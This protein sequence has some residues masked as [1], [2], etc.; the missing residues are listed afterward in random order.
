MRRRKDERVMKYIGGQKIWLKEKYF[1][2]LQ[3]KN[4]F[5]INR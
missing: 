4:E 5:A 1:V 3:A 2:L